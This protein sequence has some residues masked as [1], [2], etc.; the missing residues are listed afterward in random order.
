M[1]MNPETS[2]IQ[3]PTSNADQN[4]RAGKD[5]SGMSKVERSISPARKMWRSLDELAGT[6]EFQNARH[7]EF[8]PGASE[9]SNFNRRNFLK[10]LGGSL[11][12]ASLPAC[13][14]QPIQKIVPYVKQPEDLVPGKPMFFATAMTLGG[15]ATGLLA[16][17]HEGH[18]TKLEGNPD[19]PASLGATNVFHQGA[20]LD[21]YDP[22]R[23]Q[24]VLKN[25]DPDTWENFVSDIHDVLSAPQNKTGGGLRILTETVSSPTLAAQINELLK[26]YPSARWHQYEPANRDNVRAG[27]RLAFGEIVETQ[28]HFE[29]AKIIVSLD[30]D[31]LFAHLNSVRYA[32][33]YATQRRARFP[34]TEMS[35]L[36]VIESSPTVTGSNADN[37][38]PLRGAEIEPFARALAEKLGAISGGAPALQNHSDWISAIAEDLSQNRGESIVIAGENQPPPVHAL[39]HT[40]NHFLGN[41]GK[42][43]AFTESA[44]ASPVIQTNSLRELVDALKH[45]EVEALIV[46][47]SNPAFD[48][49]MDFAFAQ[50]LARAKFKAHLSSELNET[51]ALCDWHIPQN[52]FLESWSD[53]RSFDGTVSIVQPLILPLYAGK[54]AH[55]VLDAMLSPPGRSDYDIVH[56]FWHSKNNGPDFENQWRKALHDGLI[57]DTKLPEKKVSLRVLELSPA[58]P[59]SDAIE[60]TFRPDAT[61]FDGRFANNG[62]LQ[63]L[64]KPITK[65]TW[66]NPALIS[67]AFA[68]KQ[69]L[70]NGEVVELQFQNRKLRVPVWVTPGQTDNSIALYL[71]YGRKQVGKVGKD[72]GFNVYELRTANAFWFG[73]GV[74]LVKTGG[75][76]PLAT[77]QNQQVIDSEE[78]Q[79]FREG[80]LDKFRGDP[81]FIK[82]D[83]DLPD[84][85]DTLFKPNEFKYDGYRWG[86]AID[87]SA[88]IGCNA[89]TIACQAENNIP[90]VGKEEVARGRVMH[91]IRVDSYF[92]GAPANPEMNHQP[93]P[94]MQC[95]NAPCELVCPVDAT[96]HDHEGLNVQVYNRCIGTRYCSN[97]CPY[98]VRRFNFFFYADYQTPSL[99]P[100]RNPN[101]TVRWR[102][103]MEKCTYCLQRISAA[104]INSEEQNRKIRDGEIKTACQQVCPANAIVFGDIGDPNNR[105]AKLKTHKLNFSMLGQ[106]NTRPRTTY[107]A[108]LRNP[109]PK[110]SA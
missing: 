42:T 6:K 109:N 62:W 104:R 14:K 29:K 31:F 5:E 57:A 89:C 58:K 90:V 93:V 68:D 41:V 3:H 88:C 83:T 96:V 74:K 35:R 36:Y 43:V 23:S 79:V 110:L 13:T 91:W 63:E 28:F 87:L 65:L 15:F 38:L 102:G 27:A 69:Q 67:P 21:L 48:A 103:V 22:D 86:M 55:E 4:V 100:M 78:R 59:A 45:D 107:L 25:G 61:I 72:A 76:Y 40:M 84:K 18:P 108:K 46:F 66:D 97:N 75:H 70:S 26:K 54:S 92:R 17:S 12:L 101:V 16:E 19:H 73:D 71:G 52:H 53:A 2:N 9:S 20:L 98:K 105:V 33:D 82:K 11:A 64:P 106:L 56:D 8:P 24:A 39:A 32:R 95:E 99:K 94:C 85:D 77:T 60:I 50:N 7:R 30:S 51:S 49:P 1:N 81:D 37:R 80:T 44:E 34:E 10:L 47:G